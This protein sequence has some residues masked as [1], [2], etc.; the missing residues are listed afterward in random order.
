MIKEK[1][2][3]RT[4]IAATIGG[5]CLLV[6]Q[7]AWTY[8]SYQLEYDG[9]MA[10]IEEALSMAYQKE[11]TYRVPIADIVN[12]GE[13]SIQSCGTEEIIIVRKCFNSDTIVYHNTTGRSV[14]SFIRNVFWDL[15]EH[16]VPLNIYCLSDLFSGMLH[17]KDIHVSYLIER[18]NIHTGAVL[19]TSAFAYEKQLIA[20]P[21][22]TII[23]EISEVE[24]IRAVIEVTPVVIL[25]NMWGILLLTV[26][27]FIGVWFPIVV[28]CRRAR[29]E[30]GIV[31]Y[32]KS[33]TFH[34]GMYTF[35][36]GRNELQG[37]GEVI[38]LNKKENAILYALCVNK[39]DVVER[40]ALLE[41]NWGSSGIVYSRSL[42]TYLA[43]LRKFLKKDAT[44]QIVTVKGVGYKLVCQE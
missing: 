35:N 34:I 5:V 2:N 19:E 30:S 24:A 43:S 20:K 37:F 32:S 18:Y 25:K 7:L 31:S 38:Q 3:G 39:G 9:L 15:R 41:E 16:I 1:K 40:N 27:L 21:D 17:D 28:L 4:I 14:E 13:V 6:L 42:D 23:L 22:N 8:Y 12:P 36:P 29:L 11:Q 44:I 26:F 10:E 33:D